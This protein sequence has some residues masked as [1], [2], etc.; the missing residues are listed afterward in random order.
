MVGAQEPKPRWSEES[1]SLDVFGRNVSPITTD[2]TSKKCPRL[3]ARFFKR[4]QCTGGYGDDR[5]EVNQPAVLFLVG[6][7]EA[8]SPWLYFCSRVGY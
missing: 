7:Q 1:F 6:T 8:V 3:L 5:P 2:V 4:G